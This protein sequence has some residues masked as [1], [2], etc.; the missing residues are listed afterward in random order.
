MTAGILTYFK[1]ILCAMTENMHADLV[2]SRQAVFV[3]C[4]LKS[5]RSDF[6]NT[7]SSTLK[8]VS[9]VSPAGSVSAS[10][11]QR[12]LPRLAKIILENPFKVFNQRSVLFL[13]YD[14][15]IRV[16]DTI[17]IISSVTG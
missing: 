16:T 5:F 13:F 1:E 15:P 14:K 6:R 10:S 17:I 3:Q 7:S 8:Y 11:S 4:C 12:S 2:L 9:I